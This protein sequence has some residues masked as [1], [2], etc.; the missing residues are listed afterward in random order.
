MTDTEL[1]QNTAPE[2]PKPKGKGGARP[3][4]GAKKGSKQKGTI[5]KERA[6]AAFRQRV[7]ED[8]LNL[9]LAAKKLAL[10]GKD[11]RA[12]ELL[13]N[14]AFGRPSESVDITSGGEK[15]VGF[16]YI[17]PKEDEQS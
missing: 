8:S 11:V 7:Y 14:R 16:N 13:L 17:M 2:V 9:Y 1:Q 4:S 6:L 3:G 10:E 5:T 15:V 12:I